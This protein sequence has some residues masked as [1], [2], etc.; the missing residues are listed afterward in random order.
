MDKTI[1]GI[2]F[3]GKWA[4]SKC[5]LRFTKRHAF[6]FHDWLWWENM[7]GLD[8]KYGSYN[9]YDTGGPVDDRKVALRFW[10]K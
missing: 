9:T 10:F 8:G 6:T 4:E 1:D 5:R 2:G 3:G 7:V